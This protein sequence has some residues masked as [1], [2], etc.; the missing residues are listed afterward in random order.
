MRLDDFELAGQR[1]GNFS[2]NAR[3]AIVGVASV[4]FLVSVANY[5]F[6]WRLFGIPEKWPFAVSATLLFLTMRFLGPTIH[7]LREQRDNKTQ[8]GS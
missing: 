2:T 3:R 1:F 8:T 7:E 4:P 6:T 5:W